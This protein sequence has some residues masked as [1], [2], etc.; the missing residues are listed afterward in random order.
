MMLKLL[1]ML[2]A[3]PTILESPRWE[4]IPAVERVRY[5]PTNRY[6]PYRMRLRTRYSAH[7]GE[8]SGTHASP[9]AHVRRGHFRTQHYGKNRQMKRVIWIKHTFVN[10]LR[11]AS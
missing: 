1:Y 7:E 10:H 4:D 11:A 9:R 8:P 6:V 3:D 2:A 5:G